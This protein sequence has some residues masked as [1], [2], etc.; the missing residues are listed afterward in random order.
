MLLK[1]LVCKTI[2]KFNFVVLN[3]FFFLDR[4][5]QSA[6]GRYDG[7]VYEALFE[8]ALRSSLNQSDPFDGIEV[9]DDF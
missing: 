4:V 9:S 3:S 6:I 7:N 8:S 1:F 5:L 2:L